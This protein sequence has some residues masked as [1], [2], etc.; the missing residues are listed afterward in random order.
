MPSSPV[1]GSWH[2][3]IS[4]SEKRTTKTLHRAA[5]AASPAAPCAPPAP[6][7]LRAPP[8][9]GAAAALGVAAAAAH[10]LASLSLR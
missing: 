4:P 10:S 9:L 5:A 2:A 1:R 3:E 6:C 7:A 8:P